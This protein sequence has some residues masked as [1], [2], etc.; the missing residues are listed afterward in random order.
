MSRAAPRPISLIEVSP[1]LIIA[2]P[3]L[4][5]LAPEQARTTI[6]GIT[7]STIAFVM[8]IP[9]AVRAW[10]TRHDAHALVGLSL[11]TQFLILAN[12]TIWGVYAFMLGEFWVGA[13]G[14]I[15]APL[16]VTVIVLTV[17]SRLSAREAVFDASLSESR[18]QTEP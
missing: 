3:A 13:P 5:L 1:L 10:R 4:C 14:I 11:S 8:F 17:R 2:I 7:A 18:R 15:N 9:Q 16:A 12:A 6:L